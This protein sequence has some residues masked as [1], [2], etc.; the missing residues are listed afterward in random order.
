MVLFAA[1]HESASFTAAHDHVSN[2]SRTGHALLPR[3]DPSLAPL[4]HSRHIWAI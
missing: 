4:T 3:S 2:R 1:V